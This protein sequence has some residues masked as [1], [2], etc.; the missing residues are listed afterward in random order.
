MDGVSRRPVRSG[1]DIQLRDPVTGRVRPTRV[2]RNLSGA[3]AV[4]NEPIDQ[5][6][7]FRIETGRTFYRGPVVLTVNPARDGASHVVAL[8]RRP[9]APFDDVATLV[10]G[11][12]V[13]SGPDDA[14]GHRPVEP[15]EGVR[16]TVAAPLQ[17]RLFPATTDERGAFALAVGLRPP[18]PDE[19]Q[20][21]PATLLF[22]EDGQPARTLDV[23]LQHGRVHIFGAPVDLDGTD[24]VR[25]HHE[26]DFGSPVP[27]E[28]D[29]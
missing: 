22:E 11:L 18:G 26:P 29:Q 4:L 19:V 10:R 15:V 25:F 2:V 27:E 6:L 20:T 1:L 21:V 13:R 3:V 8:E 7:T 9:D 28:P 12:V 16:I 23:A 17:L 14:D 5:D 24:P